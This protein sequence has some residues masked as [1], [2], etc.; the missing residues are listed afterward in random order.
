MYWQEV[1]KNYKTEKLIPGAIYTSKTIRKTPNNIK[2]NLMFCYNI[3]YE[4]EN[5][6]WAYPFYKFDKKIRCL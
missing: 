5:T 6:I 2:S 3:L 1:I 4:L